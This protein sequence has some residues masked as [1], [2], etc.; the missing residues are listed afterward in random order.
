MHCIL[1]IVLYTLF[2]MHCILCIL[3]IAF[4]L[5]LKPVADW[6]TDHPTYQ[7]TDRWTR[8]RLW[9]CVSF[10][11]VLDII[12]LAKLS[13]FRHANLDT[14]TSWSNWSQAPLSKQGWGWRRR[15]GRRRQIRR[16][17]PLQQTREWD[18]IYECQ[19]A[20]MTGSGTF[21][22]T[23]EDD[24]DHHEVIP[25]STDIGGAEIGYAG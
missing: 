17:K 9:S 8:A 23:Q 16:Y 22:D 2:S 1:W 25:G 18:R 15:L 7:Q 3:T 21:R 19:G 11:S 24:P 6:Q 12:R 13:P 5:T 10:S 20:E 4:I 14:E